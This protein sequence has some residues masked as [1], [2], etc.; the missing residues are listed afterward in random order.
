MG[1]Y[2]RPLP[3]GVLLDTGGLRKL[4][5]IQLRELSQQHLLYVPWYIIRELFTTEDQHLVV[6]NLKK[7]RS[8]NAVA[9]DSVAAHL[10]F[11]LEQRKSSG[12]LLVHS[13][14]PGFP[15]LS[16]PRMIQ[17]AIDFHNSDG[18]DKRKLM[19]EQKRYEADSE[20]KWLD[21]CV[22]MVAKL[23]Q[24]PDMQ[25]LRLQFGGKYFEEPDEIQKIVSHWFKE[26]LLKDM[27]DVVTD[28]FPI[29]AVDPTWAFNRFLFGQVWYHILNAKDNLKPEQYSHRRLN[30]RIDLMGPLN[31]P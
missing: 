26:D 21:R 16:Y 23:N 2:H 7:L 22:S 9:I 3:E 10:K 29:D 24:L 8:L 14:K 27:P 30:D 20:A 19:E 17:R 12:I 4:S 13:Q 31:N 1:W 25:H 6:G 28:D 11:E 18:L 5:G 15:E